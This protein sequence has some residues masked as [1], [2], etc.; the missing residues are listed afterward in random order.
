LS[1]GAEAAFLF[2]MNKRL[3]KAQ[4]Q[5]PKKKK[6]KRNPLARNQITNKQPTAPQRYTT[7]IAS[8]CYKQTTNNG[9]EKQNKSAA[10]TNTRSQ[11]QQEHYRGTLATV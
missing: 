6:K 11:L 7:I 2:L 8:Y 5:H 9:A 10:T 4:P 1:E 3:Y